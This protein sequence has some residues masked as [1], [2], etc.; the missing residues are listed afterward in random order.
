MQTVTHRDQIIP[1]TIPAK[2]NFITEK[3]RFYAIYL[4]LCLGPRGSLSKS[5][6]IYVAVCFCLS[7]RLETERGCKCGPFRGGRL[8]LDPAVVPQ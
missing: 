2:L 1:Y 8:Q 5:F 4:C 6:G 3:Y 7:V